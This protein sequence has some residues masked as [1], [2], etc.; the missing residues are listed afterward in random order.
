MPD[1][2]GGALWRVVHVEPTTDVVG[3]RFVEGY[4]VEI[5]VAGGM[6]DTFFVSSDL[7]SEDYVAALATAKAGD[8]VRIAGLSG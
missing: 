5:E 1:G 7:F 4:Q 8:L 6:R 2:E 3:Q